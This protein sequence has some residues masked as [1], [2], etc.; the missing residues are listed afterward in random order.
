MK[1]LVVAL[2][3]VSVLI[4]GCQRKLDNENYVSSSDSGTVLEGKII[5]ARPV[6]IQNKDRLE[7][8]SAGILSGGAA[9]GVAGYQVGGGRGNAAATV[10]GAIAGALVG[11]LLQQELSK[12]DGFEYIVKI[13]PE[14]VGSYQHIRTKQTK[15]QN[16]NNKASTAS[17][18]TNFKSDMV[19]IIQSAETVFQKDQEVYIIYSDDRP[20]LAV[21]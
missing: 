10:G 1:Q 8:N 3:A 11:G 5:S 4:T 19:S 12:Q 14:Y 18:D 20:R 17:I 13:D 7:D 21:K 16:D 15:K 2:M 6:V 9:G